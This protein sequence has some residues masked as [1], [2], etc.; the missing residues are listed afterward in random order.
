MEELYWITRLGTINF[1]SLFI[2]FLTL[3]IAVLLGFIYLADELTGDK[4]EAYKIGRIIKTY[5]WKW[6]AVFSVCLSACIFIPTEEDMLL[7]YGLGGAIDYVKSNEKAKE[8]PDKVVNALDLYF[9][10]IDKDSNNDNGNG[11]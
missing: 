3:F 11:E 10:N 5:F 1:I 2:F 4:D 8:L 7:I 9:D 6:F